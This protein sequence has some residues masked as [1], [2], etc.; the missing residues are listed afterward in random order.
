[1]WN[2]QDSLWRFQNSLNQWLNEIIKLPS[3]LISPCEHPRSVNLSPLQL[4]GVAIT[5]QLSVP[6]PSYNHLNVKSG[7]VYVDLSKRLPETLEAFLHC[8]FL[9][10][11]NKIHPK[12][13]RIGKSRIAM[14]L[15]IEIHTIGR[16]KRSPPFLK[17]VAA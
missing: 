10:L 16:F 15:V 17:Q 13:I 8:S 9:K 2:Q 11:H 6:P 5:E 4:S 7:K 12:S 3:S 14:I 1:M